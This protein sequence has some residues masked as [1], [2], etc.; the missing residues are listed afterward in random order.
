MEKA[1]KI[2]KKLLE[3][4]QITD[5][6]DKDLYYDYK[7]IDTRNIL[8]VLANEL[9]FK[10]ISAP[11]AVYLV[12]NIENNLMGFSLK[13]IRESIKRDARQIDTFL[14]CY[15]IM[16]ILY[17]FYGGKNKN[18]KQADFLQIKDIVKKLDETLSVTPKE[19]AEKID[20]RY[21]I[22]FTEMAE[23]WQA[24]ALF[25]ENKLK[26]RTGTVLAACRLLKNEKLIVITD[27]D[28]EIRAT[29]KL[30]DLME[31]YYLSEDRIY[32]INDIFKVG[33]S[34]AKNQ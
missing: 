30:D 23:Y 12:P 11:H 26:T 3:K 2:Y 18:P 1:L 29:K 21:S 8:E 34:N 9:E 16:T 7:E 19:E 4:G 15:V 33:E 32:E 24:K 13:D 10:L 20:E 6:E 5:T 14:E 25:E 28:T 31:Y 22:N 27:D 17:M